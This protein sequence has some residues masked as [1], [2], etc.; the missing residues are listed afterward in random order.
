MS[1]PGEKNHGHHLFSIKE[2][3]E[4]ATGKNRLSDFFNLV[5]KNSESVVC[6]CERPLLN[7]GVKALIS[8]KNIIFSGVQGVQYDD[9]ELFFNSG[10]NCSNSEFVSLL[11]NCFYFFEH[12]SF[13]FLKNES[14]LLACKEFCLN[15][16]NWRSITDVF[17]CCFVFKSVEEDVVWY[18][19]SKASIT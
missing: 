16:K 11:L 9:F 10:G 8:S 6:L 3:G 1:I 7:E 12:L 14:D 4:S 19:I 5:I 15:D 17:E 2:V 13:V 18:R